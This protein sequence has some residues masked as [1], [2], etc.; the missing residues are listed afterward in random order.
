MTKAKKIPKP[1]NIFWQ[2]YLDIAKKTDRA[3]FRKLVERIGYAWQ[4]FK[5]TQARLPTG[6]LP[7]ELFKPLCRKFA[8]N[9]EEILNQNKYDKYGKAIK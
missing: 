5:Q 3:D 6:K 1:H 4:N 2:L 9:E 8:I 7:T